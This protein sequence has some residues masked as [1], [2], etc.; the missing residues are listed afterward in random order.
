MTD[1]LLKI[2]IANDPY[3]I[4]YSSNKKILALLKKYRLFIDNCVMT[5][6]LIYK[7]DV[8]YT[9]ILGRFANIFRTLTKAEFELVWNKIYATQVSIPFSE[10]KITQSRIRKSGNSDIISDSQITASKFN[11]I[12]E[13]F[14]QLTSYL[15]DNTKRDEI[16]LYVKTRLLEKT[17][18]LVIDLYKKKLLTLLKNTI[19]SKSL[20]YHNT[21][22]SWKLSRHNIDTLINLYADSPEVNYA[23][24]N[25]IEFKTTTKIELPIRIIVKMYK[26]SDTLPAVDIISNA[27]ISKYREN[28]LK[29]KMLKETLSEY[30]IL[31]EK[32]SKALN[33]NALH[34]YSLNGLPCLT[35]CKKTGLRKKCWCKTDGYTKTNLIGQTSVYDWDWCKEPEK[36]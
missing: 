9:N 1:R 25:S 7:Q 16:Y 28:A 32:T 27:I 14:R 35:P 3:N 17:C 11:M 23:Y 6:S 13:F 26:K 33:T 12:Q 19:I 20:D 34:G 8:K 31:S 30:D 15:N 18:T 2:D 36:C 24:E 5:F 4:N 10:Y 22:F 21:L 29:D